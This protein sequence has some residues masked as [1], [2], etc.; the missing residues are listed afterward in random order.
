MTM[1]LG[2]NPF[3]GALARLVVNKLLEEHSKAP[4]VAALLSHYVGSTGSY[5]DLNDELG[6]VPETWQDWIV[7]DTR[8]RTGFIPDE[9]P[10]NT[11]PAD[12][13]NALGHF[14]VTIRDVG[15]GQREYIINDKYTFGD[16]LVTADRQEHGFPLDTL[17][18]GAQVFLKGIVDKLRGRTFG[19]P[20]GL[21]EEF[22]YGPRRVNG[23]TID[24]L[25]VPQEF[26]VSIGQPFVVSGRFVR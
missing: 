4:T 15:R 13:V 2:G 17:S 3:T 10:Y 9:D 8:G 16:T 23:K 5:Y 1:K 14:A 7:Q 21:P 19:L 6:G 25:I 26:L 22:S 24:Y 18:P 20:G 11:G 12:L